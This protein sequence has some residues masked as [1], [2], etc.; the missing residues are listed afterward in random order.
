VIVGVVELLKRI[1]LPAKLAPVVA[2]VL[3]LAAGI[4]Y[5]APGDLRQGVLMGIVL[6]LSAMGL[7]SGGKST[8][9]SIREAGPQDGGDL[10]DA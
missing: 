9:E 1:G 8:A 3:G 5:V 4:V 6:A 7:Y 2:L 10:G